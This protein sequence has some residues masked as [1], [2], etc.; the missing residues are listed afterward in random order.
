ME[1]FIYR[2][3]REQGTAHFSRLQPPPPLCCCCPDD[4]LTVHEIEELVRQ[5]LIVPFHYAGSV[6]S[7]QWR[8]S[9]ACV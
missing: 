2:D 7:L 6:G 1:V 4:L 5:L 3:G 9:R 8:L